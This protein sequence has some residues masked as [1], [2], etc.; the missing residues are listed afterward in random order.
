MQVIA[1]FLGIFTFFMPNGVSEGTLEFK[2]SGELL[3]T[4]TGEATTTTHYEV[5]DNYIFI[6][7]FGYEYV[8]TQKQDT[9]VVDLIP[10]FEGSGNIVLVSQSP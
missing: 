9:V 2:E 3:I 1:I 10:A 5:T 7:E 8:V 4:R 6:G